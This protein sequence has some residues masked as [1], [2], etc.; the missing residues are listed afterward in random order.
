MT[1][2]T[3]VPNT[4]SDQ[5]QYLIER[6][7]A[8]RDCAFLD[9]AGNIVRIRELPAATAEARSR[10]ARKTDTLMMLRG[11]VVDVWVATASDD[12]APYLVPLSLAWIDERAVIAVRSNSATARDL[13]DRPN[14]RLGLGP[15]RNVV[16][17][18]AV[19]ER[20]LTA[21]VDEALG[22][23]YAVQAGWDPRQSPG[24][25]LFVLRPIRVQAWREANEIAGRDL[26]REGR[27][28]V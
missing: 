6:S 1:T 26:R 20:E 17:M 24:F 28:L 27:W 8:G 25:V 19:R 12:G 22:T 5:S 21:T 15:T 16:M 7:F 23:V 2:R 10:A 11:A 13:R 3:S 4:D 14:A 18:D 9:P